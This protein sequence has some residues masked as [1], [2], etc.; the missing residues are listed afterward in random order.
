MKHFVGIT[1]GIIASAFIISCDSNSSDE[2]VVMQ[3]RNDSASY[4]FGYQLGGQFKRS[5]VQV[6]EDML[7][8]GYRDGLAEKKAAISDSAAIALSEALQRELS[9]SM[10]REAAKAS[11]PIRKASEKFLAENKTKEGVVTTA[12]GLQYKV[13]KMGTGKKPV[14]GS[15]VTVHYTGKLIDGKVFDSSVERGQPAT[16]NTVQVIPGWQEAVLLMPVGSKFQLF[17]PASLAYGD[18]GA[19][20]GLIPGGAALIFDVELL[21]VKD[22]K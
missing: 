17:L 22:S 10:E 5:N 6:S 20:N 21:D 18:R 4:M 3:T 12:S 14:S 8:A 1:A 15:T 11:E 7:M 19:G 2:P 16:F 13:I 9:K